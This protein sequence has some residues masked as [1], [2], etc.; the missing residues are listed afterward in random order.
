[1]RAFIHC[2]IAIA[3]SLFLA[4]FLASCGGGG[5]GGGVTPDNAP[6][7]VGILLTDAPSAQWDQA[8][9]TLTSVTLIGAD[10]G[11]VT[12][13]SGS[14]TLDLLKLGDFS[15]LF[16][17]SQNVPP[18]QYSKIRLKLSNLTLNH[19][20]PDTGA[21]IDSTDAQLVGNGKID[22]V[23]QRPFTVG[24][25]STLF[26]ELDFD[27]EKSLKITETGNGKVIVRPVVFVNIHSN[28]PGGRLSRI[29]GQIDSVDATTGT[30]ALCQTDFASGGEDHVTPH[31]H[32]GGG[33][34]QGSGGDD[35]GN[36]DNNQQGNSDDGQWDDGD[37]HTSDH[38]V[39]VN[40]DA[41]T[42]IFGSDGL[43]QDFSGL[44]AGE[45]ATVIGQLHRRDTP[46]PVPVDTGSSHPFAF[47]AF[48]IEEG[49]V[50]AFSR[51]GGTVASVV[52]ARAG[53][54]RRP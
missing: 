15:E 49:A 24:P 37:G 2:V 46:V 23:P 18:G 53:R 16:A 1:M 25:G 35:E 28:R 33:N 26:V 11:Q 42:G 19:V 44:A 32:M 17:L 7:T 30:L 43:P 13:F 40:T 41:S 36:G 27:M 5:G 10:G 9:A 14:R 52:S 48:V 12:I 8:I 50:G 45:E 6:G 20:D 34:D 21:V 39:T 4:A 29:H 47:D 51:I 54:S 3:G 38:C 31:G 22:L